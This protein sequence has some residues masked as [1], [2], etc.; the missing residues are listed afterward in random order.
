MSHLD[1]IPNR[2]Q[3]CRQVVVILTHESI[4]YHE[5]VDI[6]KD[7]RMLGCVEMFG[8]EESGGVVAPVSK[9]V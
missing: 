5:V 9:W 1:L 3:A 8:F 7:E 4:C 2:H 6:A